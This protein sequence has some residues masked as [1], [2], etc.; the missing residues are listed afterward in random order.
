V[1]LENESNNHRLM[2]YGEWS[3]QGE[4]F[5]NEQEKNHLQIG[6]KI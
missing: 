4:L 3:F 6:G 1:V 5:I 2:V